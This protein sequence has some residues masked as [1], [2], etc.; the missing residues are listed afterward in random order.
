MVRKDHKIGFG[1][2]CYFVDSSTTSTSAIHLLN[3]SCEQYLV[4]KNQRFK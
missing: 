1:M 3:T 4:R 2:I